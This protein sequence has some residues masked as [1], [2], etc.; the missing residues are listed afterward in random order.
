MLSI[1]VGLMQLSA[2]STCLPDSTRRRLPYWW[3]VW[4]PTER[5]VMTGQ[6]YFA[7]LI[8]HSSNLWVVSPCNSSTPFIIYTWLY[9]RQSASSSDNGLSLYLLYCYR[10]KLVPWLVVSEVW[11]VQQGRPDFISIQRPVHTL[12]PVHVSPQAVSV[13]AGIQQQSRRD[14]LLQVSARPYI[15]DSVRKHLG[16]WTCVYNLYRLSLCREDLTSCLTMIQP[17]L[18]S[19]SFNGPPEVW[20]VLQRNV[21]SY[22][23]L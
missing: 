22:F 6:M 3:L 11:G 10:S 2:L 4:P 12:P 23:V 8:G 19:Y 9:K 20:V 16:L 7:G 15:T 14:V 5:K 13:P 21:N 17:V 1:L 18:F